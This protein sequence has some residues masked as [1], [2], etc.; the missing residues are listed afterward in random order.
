MRQASKTLRQVLLVLDAVI[1]VAHRSRDSRCLPTVGLAVVALLAVIPLRT[2]IGATVTTFPTSRVVT[3][4][5]IVWLDPIRAMTRGAGPRAVMPPIVRPLPR[6]MTLDPFAVWGGSRGDSI[7]AGCW[8]R[9]NA[10]SDGNLRMS[11]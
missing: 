9:T 6:P 3:P 8:R 2:L 10:Y 7:S 11:R 5:R 4:I 1:I